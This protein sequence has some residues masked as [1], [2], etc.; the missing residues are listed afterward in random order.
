MAINLSE[1]INIYLSMD[2][3]YAKHSHWLNNYTRPI[4]I[5]Q[6]KKTIAGS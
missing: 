3:V 4:P 1:Y 5:P 6:N 2:N